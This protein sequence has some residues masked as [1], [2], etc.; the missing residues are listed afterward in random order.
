MKRRVLIVDD[1][2]INRLILQNILEPDYEVV[3][4]S[5]GKEAL[6]VV[7]EEGNRFS[8]ILLDLLM[9][10]MD[11]YE[12]FDNLKKDEKYSQIP[13][14]VLTSEKEEELKSLS[15]GVADFIPKPYDVPEVI[16]ARIG[17]IIQLY[18]DHDII[19]ATQFD[20]L[21]GLFN[22]EYFC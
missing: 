18:E 14:I 21:T 8:L 9:P 20:T 22:K 6:D 17:R 11:G 16:K 4:A 12:F 15:I 13:V 7:K 19:T 2:E 10:V 5:N 1:E 3:L